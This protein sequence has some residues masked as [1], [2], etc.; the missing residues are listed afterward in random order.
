M[1]GTNLV[2]PAQMSYRVDKVKFMDKWTD[3][4]TDAGN[5]NTPS[6]LKGQGVKMDMDGT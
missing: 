4:Q 3:G 2:I 5:N 6:Y 1:F